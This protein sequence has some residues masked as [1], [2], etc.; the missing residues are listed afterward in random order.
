MTI[1]NVY[2]RKLL[3][4]DWN[5]RY[6]TSAYVKKVPAPSKSLES[7]LFLPFFAFLPLFPSF[8]SFFCV[9]FLC[10]FTLPKVSTIKR[11]RNSTKWTSALITDASGGARSDQ[12]FFVNYHCNCLFPTRSNSCPQERPS[13][14]STPL[15]QHQLWTTSSTA[16][17][18]RQSFLHSFQSD[19]KTERQNILDLVN[20]R[21]RFHSKRRSSRKLF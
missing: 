16:T 13:L 12:P 8:L 20:E 9:F 3:G 14:V 6:V 18:I 17:Y 15:F 2:Q 10:C 1:R 11:F 21:D 19:P 7:L 4:Q 5:Q